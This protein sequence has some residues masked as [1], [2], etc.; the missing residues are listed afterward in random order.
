MP[1]SLSAGEAVVSFE[2]QSSAFQ[3]NLSIPTKYTCDHHLQDDL[4]G[5][6]SHE[7]NFQVPRLVR[8]PF[9]H[10]ME[11]LFLA[12]ELSGSLRKLITCGEYFVLQ[13]PF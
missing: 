3:H 4:P 12:S 7:Q 13:V 1:N 10:G 6:L 11:G 9:S 2:L 8:R 5:F